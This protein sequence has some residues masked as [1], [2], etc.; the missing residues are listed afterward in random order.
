MPPAFLCL[1]AAI[2]FLYSSSEK[3][4][5]SVSSP[6]V[7][8]LIFASHGAFT[9]DEFGVEVVGL[10]EK[11]LNHSCPLLATVMCHQSM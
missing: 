2:P 5:T 6:A 3:V 11:F 1:G 7:S 9:V 8:V 10:L 4:Y